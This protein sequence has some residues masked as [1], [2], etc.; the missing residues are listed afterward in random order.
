MA[1]PYNSIK[2]EFVRIRDFVLNDLSLLLNQKIGG[3]YLAVSLITCSCD[4]LSRFCYGKKD[5]GEQYFSERMLPQKWERVGKSLYNALRNGLVHSYETKSIEIDSK[6]L[7]LC[8]SW[9]KREHLSFSEDQKSLFINVKVLAEELKESLIKLEKELK[10]NPG[11]REIFFKAMKKD[12]VHVIR[13]MQ[14]CEYWKGL[15]EI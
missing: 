12:R 6:K 13:N 7:E 3:N 10:E 1:T 5:N 4:A 14:E 11:L 8:I 15:M 9:E 2:Q